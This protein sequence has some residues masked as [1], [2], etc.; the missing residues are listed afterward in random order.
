MSEVTPERCTAQPISW[1]EL[2]R[3]A[4]GEAKGAEQID[5]H[6]AECAGCE[7]IM[8]RIRDDR[9]TMPG[10]SI[11]VGVQRKRGWPWRLTLVLAPLAVLLIIVTLRSRD[12]KGS[13]TGVKGAEPSFVLIRENAS[14]LLSPTHFADGDR[15]KIQVS[16][17]PSLGTTHADIVVSQSGSLFYPLAPVRLSCGNQVPVPGAFYIDGPSPALVCLVLS[18]SGP[19][20]RQSIPPGSLCVELQPSD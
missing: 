11:P 17:A 7:Q 4:L 8:A 15:F 6:L 1:L 5:A 20:I 9:R 13:S 10:L 16:C 3:H 12:P 19:P 14:R 2:E 18:E